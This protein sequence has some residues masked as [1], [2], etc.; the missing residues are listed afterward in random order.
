MQAD[1]SDGVAKF[2]RKLSSLLTQNLCG[3]LALLRKLYLFHKL[4]TQGKVGVANG[5]VAVGCDG[6]RL[7]LK[8][9]QMKEKNLEEM[10]EHFLF[11]REEGRNLNISGEKEIENSFK[12]E[13]TSLKSLV[14]V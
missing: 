14:A 2:S 4:F 3:H 12:S 6:R 13:L 9:L 1:S 5:K 10:F 7:F 8:T 11:F